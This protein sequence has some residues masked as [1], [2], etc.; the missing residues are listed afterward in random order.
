LSSS[1]EVGSLFSVRFDYQE[2][3]VPTIY[4]EG[5]NFVFTALAIGATVLSIL[6]LGLLPCV[7]NSADETRAVVHTL[8]NLLF[9]CLGSL[10][11]DIRYETHS[12]G[13][14]THQLARPIFTQAR[15]ASLSRQ[16][17]IE[18][19]IM[20]RLGYLVGTAL[21]VITRTADLAIGIITLFCLPLLA[22]SYDINS[23]VARELTFL[24]IIDDVCRGIR[25][26]INPHQFDR[27][28]VLYQFL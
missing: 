28:R 14:L 1:T 3:P 9:H 22:F 18:R 24:G 5:E 4:D 7:N 21:C 25:G 17:V 6:S 20:S 8:P 27:E 10:G 11:V 15:S 12:C 2:N 26:V 13:Y 16:S 23:L 19:E